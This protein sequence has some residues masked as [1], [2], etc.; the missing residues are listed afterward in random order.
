MKKV[1]VVILNWNGETLLRRYLPQVLRDTPAELAD[2]VVADNGSED[3][4]LEYLSTLEGV[5]IIALGQNYGYAEGYNRAIREL[6]HPYVLLLN[7]DVRT[8]EGW[9][10]PLLRV[11][12]SEQDVVSVQP[13]I[14]WERQEEYFEYAGAQ[15]GYMDYLGYPFCRGR[16][17]GTLELDKGQYGERP[18]EVFWTTGAA[19]MVR[20][21]EFIRA[22]GFDESY[23]NHQEEIDLCWRWHC[24]GWRLLVVPESVVYHYGGASLGMENPRKTFFNFR[25]NLR[26]LYKLL[27]K[28]QLLPTLLLRIILDFVAA[29]AFFAKGNWGDAWAVVRA[30][31]AFLTSKKSRPT[32]LDRERGYKKLYPR[33]L[34][35]RY[36]W[37][38]EKYFSQ[39]KM[40]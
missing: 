11:M 27:P 33:S 8:T 1:A 4:S 34:L 23:F 28:R 18:E 36:F 30:D 20:R 29:L 6:T 3:G 13:K 5:E 16:I 9:W 19:M 2:V 17:F 21:E 26:M 31:F 14:R 35:L 10:E 37:H 25:N 22:G 32:G 12:E 15:G 38:K 24:S 7:S 39:L 40:D